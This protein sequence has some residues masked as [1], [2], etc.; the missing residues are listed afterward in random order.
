MASG[1]KAIKAA[2]AANSIIAVMKSMMAY[3]TGS[4]AM[5]AEAIHSWADAGNQVILLHGEKQAKKTGKEDF[6]FGAGKA[7]FFWSFVVA[8]VL[9]FVGGLYSFIEGIHKII[10]PKPLNDSIVFLGFS[11]VDLSLL[12]LSIAFFL[13]LKAFTIAAK[14][15]DLKKYNVKSFFEK[16]KSSTNASVIVILIED[17]VAMLGLLIAISAILLSSYNPVFDGIGSLIIGLLLMIM[18]YKLSHEIYSLLVGE[19]IDRD[20]RRK[21]RNIVNQY[22]DISHINFVKGMIL[23]SHKKLIVISVDIV[24][25]QTT[26]NRIEDILQEIRKSIVCEVDNTELKLIMIDVRDSKHVI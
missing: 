8:L 2:L 4:Q 23:G 5:M 21:I 6:A 10:E 24:D 25:D 9:F 16:I 7:S 15:A 1:N 26:G 13:E 11:F 12:V 17:S 22:D 3:L 20:D 14:E 19:N 18:A